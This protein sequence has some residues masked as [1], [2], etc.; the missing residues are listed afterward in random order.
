[1]YLSRITTLCRSVV[2][3]I[4][5]RGEYT[6]HYTIASGSQFSKTDPRSWEL[7]GSNNNEDFVLLDSRSDEVFSYRMEKRSFAINNKPKNYRYYKFRI[8]RSLVCIMIVVSN[9]GDK[10]K[11]ALSLFSL[12]AQYTWLVPSLLYKRENIVFFEFEIVHITPISSGYSHFQIVNTTNPLPKGLSFNVN[13]GCLHGRLHAPL[14]ST[15]ITVTAE[16]MIDHTHDS[17]TFSLEGR[18]CSDDHSIIRIETYNQEM[19]SIEYWNLTSSEG[20]ITT[21]GVNYYT[22]Q[23]QQTH[24]Y[25]ILKEAIKVTGYVDVDALSEE[26]RIHQVMHGVLSI[27][28]PYPIY[29]NYP[30]HLVKD[31]S[32]YPVTSMTIDDNKD[33]NCIVNTAFA[34]SSST[35]WKANTDYGCSGGWKEPS[36]DDHK[37][38]DYE[39]LHPTGLS[40]RTRCF[41]TWIS[42]SD[43]NTVTSFEFKVKHYAIVEVFINGV[44]YDYYKLTT[45]RYWM[46]VT[47]PPIGF[48]DGNNLFAIKLSPI[49]RALDGPFTLHCVG[50]FVYETEECARSFDMSTKGD[51]SWPYVTDNLISLDLLSVWRSEFNRG[52]VMVSFIMNYNSHHVINK[53]CLTNSPTLFTESSDPQQWVVFY[54]STHDGDWIEVDHQSEIQWSNRLQTQCFVLTKPMIATQTIVFRFDAGYGQ[55]QIELSYVSFHAIPFTKAKAYPLLYTSKE[56]G[57]YVNVPILEYC[58]LYPYFNFFSVKP[59]LPSGLV[60]NKGTGCISGAVTSPFESQSYTIFAQRMNSAVETASTYIRYEECRYPSVPLTIG[61]YRYQKSGSP[62][63]LEI[64]L[65]S[66]DWSLVR[67]SSLTLGNDFTSFTHCLPTDLFSFSITDYSAQGDLQTQWFVN[68]GDYT[69]SKGILNPGFPQLWFSMNVN[70]VFDGEKTEWYY[71]VSGREPPLGWYKQIDP[72]WEIW[73]TAIPSQIPLVHG[74]TQYYKTVLVLPS[75]GDLYSVIFHIQLQ[76]GVIVYVNGKEVYRYNLPHGTIDHTT[77]ATDHFSSPVSFTIPIPVQF[78]YFIEERNIIA[79]ETHLTEPPSKPQPSLFKIGIELE[80]DHSLGMIDSEAIDMTATIETQLIVPIPVINDGNYYN[81]FYRTSNCSQQAIHFF[82]PLGQ[83]AYVTLFKLFTGDS[84]DAYPHEIKLSGRLLASLHD[85]EKAKLGNPVSTEWVELLDS[86]DIE[87]SSTHYGSHKDFQFYN[88]LMMN[89]FKFELN[90]CGKQKGFEIAEIAFYTNRIHGF[91]D[92]RLIPTNRSLEVM[93]TKET[94]DYSMFIPSKSWY[95]VSCPTYYRGYMY[96][97]CQNGNWTTVTNNCHCKPPLYFKYSSSIVY[98]TMRRSFS[99]MPTSKGA[100]LFFDFKEKVPEGIQIRHDTGEIYGEVRAP[101]PMTSLT[102]M[103]MNSNGVLETSLVIMTVNNHESLLIAV[104]ALMVLLFIIV[105]E[106]LIKSMQKKQQSPNKE[107]VDVHLH[108]DGLSEELRSFI[109]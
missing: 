86:K 59:D 11:T 34:I 20:V 7:Y 33:K 4:M 52:K 12:N 102:V 16:N 65:F 96:Y 42:L 72:Q 19:S 105:M 51:S 83:P 27:A 106:S 36:F 104:A 56:I 9:N 44:S 68:R 99:I 78:S 26:K 76:A 35:Q 80:Y 23:Y 63:I 37:W 77:R 29:D 14:S 81:K 53:Y 48:H 97:Y 91:C 39:A 46:T 92:T 15:N 13:T 84:P 5:F 101:I 108:V 95:K 30:F 103:C 88:E 2:V 18:Q 41:R 28:L 85:V 47:I 49:D 24:Y 25:C 75:L 70:D 100:E 93:Q 8:C 94:T 89:E 74:I 45:D 90:D 69:V 87:F 40:G 17:F 50:R 60:L 22:K 79:I 61:F 58:P 73:E 32:F 54:V 3:W 82:T 109:L 55:H 67:F 71:D 31:M 10:E 1:M 21:Q 43:V 57:A 107:V 38:K 66:S 62:L 64:S 6:N 98:L